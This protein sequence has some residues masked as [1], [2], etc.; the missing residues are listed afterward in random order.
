MVAFDE[1]FPGVIAELGLAL[2]RTDDI[3]ESTVERIVSSA[4]RGSMPTK[5]RI[6]SNTGR[7]QRSISVVVV[8]E[9]PRGTRV[10]R[11]A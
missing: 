9:N 2:G 8:G 11:W 1:V 7:H 6:V 10:L 3:R 5:R 4:A